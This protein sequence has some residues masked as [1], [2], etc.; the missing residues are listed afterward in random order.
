M[1]NIGIMMVVAVVYH[2]TSQE[3]HTG[4]RGAV[5]KAVMAVEVTAFYEGRQEDGSCATE[6][7][8]PSRARLQNC[9]REE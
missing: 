4:D 6:V 5:E 9:A 3:C 2:M 7:D 8:G 1:E